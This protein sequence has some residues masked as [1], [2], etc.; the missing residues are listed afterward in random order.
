[1]GAH[2][3]KTGPVSLWRD[4]AG[5]PPAIERS[6][7][8]KHVDVAIIGGGYTGLWTALHLLRQS[9]DIKLVVL[10]RTHVG[11]GASGRNGGWASAL[12]PTA[13]S[14]IARESGRDA[15]LAMQHAM[16]RAVDD[17]GTWAAEED[18]DCDF[19]KGGI[20]M[21]S[22]NAG[23]VANLRHEVAGH[24]AWGASDRDWELLDSTAA[25]ARINARGIEAGAFTPHCAAIHPLKLV[26]GLARA[27][28]RRGGRIFE[29]VTVLSYARG[30]VSTNQGVLTADAIVRATEGFTARFEQHRN[31][32]MP[33]YSQMLATEPLSEAQ[34]SEIGLHNRETFSENRH[35]VIYGQR[36]ADGRFAFGGRGSRYQ[37]AS[38]VHPSM[39]VNPRTHAYLLNTL[40]DFFPQL[41]GVR[42]THTWGGALGV[43]RDYFPSVRFRDGLGTAGGYVGDGVASSALAGATMADLI[44]EKQTERTALPWVN[45][46]SRNWE[47]E[48]LRWIAA[49]AMVTGLQ[50]ADREEERTGKPSRIADVLY[51]LL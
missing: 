22:R 37:W 6:G 49:N 13:M 39:D 46:S 47:P 36:T 26:H 21:F 29:G 44:L 3:P 5:S 1:M 50:F 48:P 30:V 16:Y 33:L 10:E 15:A 18:I 41:R 23:Q 42:I 7:L 25:R 32:M 38:R 17:L 43:P 45:R 2:G 12:F 24:R 40:L 51:R 27:V 20:I 14:K 34:W 9:P 19:A 4:T 31:A 11:F 35:V 8:P 28:L